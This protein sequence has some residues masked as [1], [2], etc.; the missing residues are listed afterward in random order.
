MKITVSGDPRTVVHQ[1]L[2][3]I[4]AR[5]PQE[6]YEKALKLGKEGEAAYKNPGGDAVN[7]F[8]E[9]IS[10]LTE[11]C[12]ELED[13]SELAYRETVGMPEEEIRALIRPRDSLPAFLAPGRTDGPDYAS[14]EIVEEVERRFGI[15]HPK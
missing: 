11:I 12:E 7:I 10:D 6:A 13:G 4:L 1:D 3:L 5:T 15:K 9:G 8:F 14:G 2:T